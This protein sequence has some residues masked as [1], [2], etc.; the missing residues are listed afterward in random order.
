M[1]LGK[2]NGKFKR[3]LFVDSG[4]IWKIGQRL[5]TR[6]YYRRQWSNKFDA[7]IY[8]RVQKKKEKNIH[9]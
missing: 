8:S 6:I 4:T 5:A 3:A 1:K 2:F 9:K 7:V